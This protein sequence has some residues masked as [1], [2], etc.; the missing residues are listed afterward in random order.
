MHEDTHIYS[1][2]ENE[3]GNPVI[4]NIISDPEGNDVN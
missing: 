4:H 3:K 1:Y 2:N